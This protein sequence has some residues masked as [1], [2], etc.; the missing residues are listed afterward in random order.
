MPQTKKLNYQLVSQ[1][2][3]YKPKNRLIFARSFTKIVVERLWE[4]LANKKTLFGH[5]SLPTSEIFAFESCPIPQNAADIA[6]EFGEKTASLNIIS[7][8]YFIGSVYT[9]LIPKEVRS[10]YG[11][12]YTPP[13][14]VHRLLDKA[15]EAGIDWSTASVLD[16]GCGGGAFLAPVAGR[17]A[18]AIGNNKKEKIIDHISMKLRGIEIDPFAAWLSQIFLELMIVEKCDIQDQSIPVVVEIKDTLAKRPQE[19]GYDLII[20]NPPYGKTKLSK[21]QRE[22]FKRSLYG[23]ANLYGLFTDQALYHARKG[24]LVAYVTPTSFLSGQY[25]K[26]LRSLLST[27]APLVSVDFIST[28][29]GVFDNVLQETLLAIFRKGGRNR[30][31]RSSVL[32][33]DS[34]GKAEVVTAGKYWLPSKDS[35][36]WIIPRLKK[37]SKLVQRLHKMSCRLKDYGYNVSTGP[38]VWNRHKTQLRF[39]FSEGCY[40]LIW[41]ESVTPSGQFLFKAEKINHQPFFMPRDHEKWV[42]TKC[43]CVLLQRTTAKEQKR[44]LIASELPQ[45]FIKKFGGVVV[46]NHLNMIK[47]IDG[48]PMITPATIAVFFN[49]SALDSVFRCINGSVAVSAYE[50]EAMPLPDIDQAL[51]IQTLIQ[52]GIRSDEINNRLERIYA[53]H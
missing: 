33:V 4:V 3:N 27:A 22:F 11:V 17:I 2:I 5:H 13:A 47:P 24:G 29:S 30:T 32:K 49:S 6:K 31:G 38:L 35:S 16:P 52:Q 14:I 8:G 10:K 15:E 28:R 1:L 34:P 37:Q 46:E 21:E 43:P 44:R 9:A 39:T 12:F 23:H 18:D 53:H 7:A 51:E 45:N 26:Q 48:K 20:G 25:F 36:P 42:V 50:I 41:A 40:P 19:P